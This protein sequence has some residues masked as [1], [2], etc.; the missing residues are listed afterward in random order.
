MVAE[1]SQERRGSGLLREIR[2]GG[3]DCRVEER[4]GCRGLRC[5]REQG[6]AAL[7]GK[8]RWGG[9]E[10]RIMGGAQRAGARGARDSER[11]ASKNIYRNFRRNRPNT[12]VELRDM[13]QR[14]A[15]QEDE[16]NKRLPKR[17]NSKCNNDHL[18]DKGQRDYSG[19]SRKRKPDDEVEVVERNPRG[20]RLR[21]QQDQYEKILHKQCLMH[22]KTKHTLFQ[23]ITLRKSINVPLPDQDGKEKKKEDDERD[24]SGA[25]GFQDPINV[26]NVIFG[27]DNDF[28]TKHAQKLTL[29]E[30]QSV[31][32]A[33][34]QSLRYNKV[35][36]SFP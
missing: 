4:C 15:G 2:D 33:I 8:G 28:P 29:R 30:I 17:N 14:W 31:E 34:H 5:G 26:V 19:S 12:V 36:I 10:G 32:P 7:Q 22:P 13:M 27:G 24:K 6:A 11:L 20:K 16:E 18:S 25:Q 35:S 1:I 23:C 3:A 21:N 9:R